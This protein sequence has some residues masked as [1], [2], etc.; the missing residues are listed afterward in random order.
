VIKTLFW[1]CL[2]AGAGSVRA[3]GQT[4]TFPI[5]CFD[6]AEQQM[7][8]SITYLDPDQHAR[9]TLVDGSWK[10]VDASNWASGFFCGCQWLLYEWTGA[11]DW[12]DRAMT[13]SADL[14]GQKNDRGSHDVG[15][16]ILSSFGNG[17]RLTGDPS[18][19]EVILDAAESLASRFDPTVGCVRSWDFGSWQFPVI[20]DN[21]MNLELFLWAA[22]NGGDPQYREMAISHARRTIEEHVRTDGSTF[23]VVDF[24]P[25]DG[26]VLWKGTHQGAAD[27]STWARGQ[28]WGIAGFAMMHRYTRDREFLV[29]ARR[30]ADDFLKRLPADGVPYWDFDAPGIP[31]EP[32]DTSAAAIAAAGLIELSGF[33]GRAGDSQLYRMAAIRILKSLSSAPY[34]AE[35]SISDGLL[36]HGVGNRPSDKEVDVTLIYGDYYF[37][38]ALLRLENR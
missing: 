17:Y 13:W 37:L 25:A 14:E 36:L 28:A 12:R 1:G 22:A 6:F 30:L 9:S 10:A 3:P 16:Q 26:S 27:G 29:A 19:R 35:G 38:E 32:R 18:Y 7:S 21:L 24:D 4:L 15:F 5:R 11:S 23:H 2:L 33:V 20:I 34:W 31:D 8:H